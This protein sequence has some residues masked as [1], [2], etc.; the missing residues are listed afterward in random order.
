[1][2]IRFKDGKPLLIGGQVAGSQSCCCENPPPPFCSCGDFCQ[3]FIEVVSPS[4]VAVKSLVAECSGSY[5]Q[6]GVV[7]DRDI[8]WL[9]DVV[10]PDQFGDPTVDCSPILGFS[11]EA[12]RG[13]A[14]SLV[15]SGSYAGLYAST[16]VRTSYVTL[17]CGL[18]VLEISAGVRVRFSCSE[19]SGAELTDPYIDITL[20]VAARTIYRRFGSPAEGEESYHIVA[21]GLRVNPE[22][23]CYRGNAMACV[24]G[25]KKVIQTPL[26][27]EATSTSTTLGAWEYSDE[28]S[29]GPDAA[30]LEVIVNQVLD[31]LAAT[32]RITS[33]PSCRTVP[34]D[35]S[36]PLEGNRII[37]FGA[38]EDRSFVLGTQKSTTTGLLDGLTVNYEHYGTAAG[39]TADPW[40]FNA[41]TVREEDNR[42]ISEHN[43]ELFCGLD[44]SVSPAVSRWYVREFTYC[45]PE[46]GQQT[47]GQWISVVGSYQANNECNDI[48]V[49]DPVPIGSPDYEEVDGYPVVDFGDPCVPPSP[50]GLTITD[51][52][53]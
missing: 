5:Q 32:F 41:K 13:F 29:G 2:E 25:G 51:L 17:P 36:V 1:V 53:P 10:L 20:D 43:V 27:I 7:A 28:M 22:T 33:R 47:T 30:M 42:T 11:N 44:D 9:D 35:C 37:T 18:P 19:T 45:T 24:P 6:T 48:S 15:G 31:N 49:G 8:S 34:T 14:S 3:Y 21:R 38:A 52:C 40:V 16:G 23:E 26:V 4:E 50:I 39:T 12:Y 46:F